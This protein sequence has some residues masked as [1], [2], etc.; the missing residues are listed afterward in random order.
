MEIGDKTFKRNGF[1]LPLN[2]W[3]IAS[4]VVFLIKITVFYAYHA[5]SLSSNTISK[6]Y[7]TVTFTILRLSFKLSMVYFMPSQ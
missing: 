4:W 5:Q 7:T 6:V 1:S 2:G 3:Q